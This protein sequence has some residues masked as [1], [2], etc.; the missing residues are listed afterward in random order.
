M[1]AI[2]TSRIDYPGDDAIDVSALTG[3]QAF[4]PLWPVVRDFKRGRLTWDEY[5]DEYVSLMRASYKENRL[6]WDHVLQRERVVLVCFCPDVSNC[7]RLL[8]AR[9]FEKLGAMYLGEIDKWSRKQV[10]IPW[11]P[12]APF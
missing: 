3:N 10:G 7:H 11:E 5:K 12:G 8:L 2:Y 6:A 4:A 1:T 9:I